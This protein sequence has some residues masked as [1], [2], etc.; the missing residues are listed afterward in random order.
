VEEV[1]LELLH[2]MWV[3][4]EQEILH[5]QVHLKEIQVEIQILMVLFNGLEAEEV[6]QV[7]LELQLVVVVLQVEQEE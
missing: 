1:V 5:Q 4:V 7:L 6:E 2:L 3:L